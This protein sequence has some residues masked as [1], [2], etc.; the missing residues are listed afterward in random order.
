MARKQTKKDSVAHSIDYWAPGARA[1]FDAHVRLVCQAD[2]RHRCEV[3]WVLQLR[4]AFDREAVDNYIARV[5]TKRGVPAAERL[6][7][8]AAQQWSLGNRGKEGSW[9][10]PQ[11]QRTLL[12]AA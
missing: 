11:A 10:E 9:F 1:S 6:L 4:A 12:E 7:N 3:R 2:E 8:D 5:T